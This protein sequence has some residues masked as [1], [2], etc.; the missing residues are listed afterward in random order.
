MLEELQDKMKALADEKFARVGS[1]AVHEMITEVAGFLIDR[2]HAIDETYCESEDG[3]SLG[4]TLKIKAQDERGQ[5]PIETKIN[6]IRVK[7][8]EVRVRFV[9]GDQLSL[10]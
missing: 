10:F 5:M 6:F 3:I 9:D 1:N 7:D 8:T 4:F 2:L